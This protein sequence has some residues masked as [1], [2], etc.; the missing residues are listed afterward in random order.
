MADNTA[1]DEQRSTDQL[2]TNRPQ[3]APPVR[4]KAPNDWIRYDPIAIAAAL[5]EARGTI[6]SLTTTPFQRAW[7]EKLQEVQLKMEVAGTSRIEGADFTERELDEALQL[8][9]SAEGLATR[10]QRQA[11]AAMQTY[12]WISQ[13]PT[14]IPVTANLILEIHRRIIAGCDDDH[15]EPGVLRR[16]DHNVIFGIPPHRG[17]DGGEPCQKAFERLVS[18]VQHEYTAHDPLV[19]ALAF[20]YHFAAMHPF[21]DGNGRTARALEAVMLRRAGLRDSAF[22]AMSNFYYDEKNQYL[23][24]LSE[25]RARQNDLTP[26]LLLGLRGVATQCKR[27]FAEIRRHMQKALFQNT[28]YELFNRLRTSKSRFMGQRQLE[29]LKLLLEREQ[30]DWNQFVAEI[31]PVYNK[32]KAPG[33]AIGRDVDGLRTLGALRIEKVGESKWTIAP[34]LEW[35]SEITESAFFAVIKKMPRGKTYS[36]LP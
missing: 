10:S 30:M 12:R 13:Q 9:P 18:A 15:C 16:P 2:E 5:A 17:C 32:L 6:Y 3:A 29:I 28:M 20:H 34:R 21:M 14:D 22:I 33:K 36:F 25:V 23:A 11:A 35:P 7:V 8:E 19:Q 4:Y 26:F 24:M 31:R 1:L 27:L